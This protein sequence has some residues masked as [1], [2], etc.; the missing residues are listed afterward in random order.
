MAFPVRIIGEKADCFEADVD[1]STKCVDFGDYYNLVAIISKVDCYIRFNEPTNKEFIHL[2]NLAFNWFFPI[3]RV[4]VRSTGE[5]GKLYVWV[6]K[7]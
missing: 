1:T 2:A 6:E 7:I 5:S 3:K 4:Y